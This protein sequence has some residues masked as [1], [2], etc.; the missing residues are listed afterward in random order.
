MLKGNGRALYVIYIMFIVNS[1]MYLVIN[2]SFQRVG[3]VICVL[4]L[5][6]F[7]KGIN[8]Q[9]KLDFG[10]ILFF[11]FI[12]CTS[13]CS[14]LFFSIKPIVYAL[15]MLVTYIV[16][17]NSVILFEKK[18]FDTLYNILS[19]I[20]ILIIGYSLLFWPLRWFNYGGALGN[21]NNAGVVAATMTTFSIIQYIVAKQRGTKVSKKVYVLL[22]IQLFF[23]LISTCRSALLSIAIQ[24]IVLI[25]G[26]MMD[27]EIPDKI[28][29]RIILIVFLAAAISYSLGILSIILDKTTALQM[30]LGDVTNGR[31]DYWIAIWEEG[32]WFNN[33]VEIVNVISH[34]V[35]FGLINQFGKLSGITFFVFIVY[36]LLASLKLLKTSYEY[37]WAFVLAT[38]NFIIISMFEN[39][40][41]T[42]PMCL[43]F[44][45]LGLN[46]NERKL[47]IGNR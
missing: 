37:K 3:F 28:I 42:L 34:N 46:R 30:R 35:Y 47:T 10:V 44:I 41:M 33:G 5:L 23:V 18:W 12:A 39:I 25:I 9:Y 27:K 21:P 1:F 40:L 4:V 24:I 14:L 8:L 19:M 20:W 29:R 26:G 11:G 38:I 17:F 45:G 13:I 36:E 43:M 16:S 7:V 32:K 22:P 31:I 15:G 2:R 6:L